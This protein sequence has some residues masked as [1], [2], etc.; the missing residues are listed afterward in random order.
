MGRGLSLELA[1][2]ELKWDSNGRESNICF[3]LLSAFNANNDVSFDSR[4]DM[5]NE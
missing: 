5:E 3:Q 2:F 4:S 1:I